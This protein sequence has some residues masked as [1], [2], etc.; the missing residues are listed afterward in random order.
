M[1]KPITINLAG[2]KHQAT[3]KDAQS[4]KEMAQRLTESS[5]GEYLAV[6]R[7]GIFEVWFRPMESQTAVLL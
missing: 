6:D 4:A 2:L 7:N 1:K 3:L 5:K